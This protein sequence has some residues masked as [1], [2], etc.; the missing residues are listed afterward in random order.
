MPTLIS[1]DTVNRTRSCNPTGSYID[2]RERSKEAYINHKA[3]FNSIPHLD[4]VQ[5]V[6]T[7]VENFFGH[8]PTYYTYRGIGSRKPFESIKVEQVGHVLSKRSVAVKNSDLYGPLLA[9]GNVKVSSKNGHLL[10]KV[11]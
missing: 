3:L 8:P 7:I 6:S 11:Y 2:A 4:R 5:A 10:I 1:E 9:L